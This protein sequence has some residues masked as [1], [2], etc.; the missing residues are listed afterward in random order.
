MRLL[1]ALVY[2]A[3]VLSKAL[4]CPSWTLS[5]IFKYSQADAVDRRAWRHLE[6]LEREGR[7]KSRLSVVVPNM[8]RSSPTQMDI[9][10][11]ECNLFR[12]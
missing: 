11:S 8:A 12:F 5:G 4:R 10:L 3:L 1:F 2:K 6:P 7:E 9:M